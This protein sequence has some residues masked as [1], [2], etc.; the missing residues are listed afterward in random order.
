MS[1]DII[2]NQDIFTRSATVLKNAL[3]CQKSIWRGHKSPS[4][5]TMRYVARYQQYPGDII[6]RSVRIVIVG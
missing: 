3:K 1:R 5:W 6:A 2:D 4:D